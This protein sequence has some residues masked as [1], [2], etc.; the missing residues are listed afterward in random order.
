MKCLSKV[1]ILDMLE[2]LALIQSFYKYL[3]EKLRLE[4]HLDMFLS[5]LEGLQL[6]SLSDLVVVLE[7]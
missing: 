4:G 7:S 5:I 1:D 3:L 2:S 6:K